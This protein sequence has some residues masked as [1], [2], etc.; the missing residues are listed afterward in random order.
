MK[1]KSRIL[2]VL[3]FAV[4]LFAHLTQITDPDLFWHLATGRWIWEHHQLPDRDLF[5]YTTSV[6]AYEDS[7]MAKIIPRQYWVANLIQYG[8]FNLAGYRGIIV[9]RLFFAF[10]TLLMVFLH[11]RRK[12]LSVITSLPLLLPLTY[13]LLQ[14]KGDRPN[15]MTFFFVA[16]FLYLIE[17]LKEA[18]SVQRVTCSDEKTDTGQANTRYP[19]HAT[20][21]FL[22][23]LLMLFWANMH[24]GFIVGTAIA[25]IYVFSELLRK[26]LVRGRLINKRLLIVSLVTIFAGLLNPN[27]YNVIYGIIKEASPIQ[28]AS[29][30]ELMTP[31]AYI[32]VGT[33]RFVTWTLLYLAA[34]AFSVTAHVILEYKRRGCG[35]RGQEPEV[36]MET[37]CTLRAILFSHSEEVLVI[38]LFGI[39]SFTAIR[40]IPLLAIAATPIIG[41]IF[42]GKADHIFLKLSKFMV[43]D[44]L[45]VSVILF[46]A[47]TIY[48]MTIFKKPIIEDYFPEAAVRFIKSRNL[49][50]RLFNYYDW[51]GYLI[52]RFYP[53][54]V[55]FM[56]GRAL[57][58]KG[59][60]QYL[61]VIS[62][63]REKIVDVPA[64]KAI[65][66]TYSVKYILIPG[67][68]REG[69][70]APLLPILV[71]DPE[72]K[73]I[74]Y[75][76]N[77]L[78]FT[79]ENFEPD[80]PKVLSYAAAMASAYTMLGTDNPRPYLTVARSELGLGRRDDAIEFLK[81]ALKKR[82]SLKGGPVEKA[83]EL[84]KNGKD[85][86]HKDMGLP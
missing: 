19:L 73:L 18:G 27:G 78:L 48:P 5:N 20:R 22:L 10:L 57:S 42:S 3:F 41:G 79:R 74:F 8:A 33:Y 83:L 71:D 13:I 59:F 6:K 52:W 12:R 54:Q 61:A 29:V 24:G 38:A 77:C 11:L 26:L 15:Q 43:P 39:L 81:D 63:D 46:G 35:A 2:L 75:A 64:Y 84:I 86:L 58:Q 65:L 23:P 70:M 60:L 51:G 28:S 62:G 25:V 82:P 69:G 9:I 37:R 21:Y 17:D 34:A 76:K 56:D 36:G 30:A 80:F 68:A 53:D 47:W 16:A 4:V 66:D 1:L 44:I 85:I 49:N 7:F 14:F 55:V 45:V 32:A 50:D 72:W 31:F 40:V 67:I